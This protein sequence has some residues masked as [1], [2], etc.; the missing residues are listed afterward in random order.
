V[1]PEWLVN[2]I[3]VLKIKGLPPCKSIHDNVYIK[4]QRPS[5]TLQDFKENTDS[6]ISTNKKNDDMTKE[7]YEVYASSLAIEPGDVVFAGIKTFCMGLVSRMNL[8]VATSEAS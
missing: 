2:E 1:E 6:L 3:S 7:I 5:Q 4:S 8:A